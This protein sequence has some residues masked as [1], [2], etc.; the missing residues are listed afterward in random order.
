M[1][2]SELLEQVEKHIKN[3]LSAEI[4]QG[5]PFHNFD[6]TFHVVQKCDELATHYNL[7]LEDREIL[8][9]AAWFHD[10]GYIRGNI[11]HEED[12]AKI[13][14]AFLN[15]R[16]L[17][18][19]FIDKVAAL[20]H[21][22][23][24]PAKPGTLLEKM[25][26]DAD[27]HHLASEDYFHWSDRLYKEIQMQSATHIGKTTW[28]KENISFFKAHHYFTEYAIGL[29]DAQKQLNLQALISRCGQQ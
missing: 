7:S 5:R 16:N 3:L 10:I 11:N 19:E 25:L 6:H 24:L 27:L 12:G 8:L 26:C 29:W 9:T 15:D 22:T 21:A 17:P 28:I 1:P 18:S 4:L 2:S 23:K 14:S 20:I 13:A